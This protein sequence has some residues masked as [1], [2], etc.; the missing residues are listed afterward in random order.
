MASRAF[1]GLWVLFLFG[2]GVCTA[3]PALNGD[4]PD[5]YVVQP[6]D[7][8]WDISGRFLREP[9][10]WKEI[11]EANPQ[12]QDPDRIYPG[13][14]LVLRDTAA[15][16]RVRI[17]SRGQVVKLSP[18]VRVTPLPHPIPTIPLEVIR[19]FLVEPLVFNNKGDLERAAYVVGNAEGRLVTGTGDKIYVK[20]V[21]EYDGS[22]YSVFRPGK[23]FRDWGRRE[24]LGYEA[25]PVADAQLL[26]SDDEV[27]KLEVLNS[28]VSVHPGD[29]V[30]PASEE[31][32]V[33]EFVPESPS[34]PV[35]GR[36]ISIPSGSRYVGRYQVVVVSLG[37]DDGVQVGDVLAT[38]TAGAHVNDPVRAASVRLPQERSGLVM[39][40]RIFDRVS[41]GLVMEA[42]RDIALGDVVTNPE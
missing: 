20:G 10:R 24:I 15:G 9:W 31:E 19:P 40:F 11:W 35:E 36:V 22:R 41:Y 23:V 26:R 38:Y 39:L 33:I 7:T 13:D 18:Q 32:P 12:V 21:D 4:H 27:S 17:E 29:R 2:A 28:Y 42:Q 6:G 3:Q 16:P 37:F 5:R 8:L 30:L 25:V 34:L 14:V 1:W